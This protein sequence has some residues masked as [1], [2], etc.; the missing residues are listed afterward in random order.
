MYKVVLSGIPTKRPDGTLV[1]EDEV[2]NDLRAHSA[3]FKELALA[4]SA[5]RAGWLLRADARASRDM[6]K[7][8]FALGCPCEPGEFQP[9][10]RERVCQR[11]WNP[12]ARHRERDFRCRERCRLCG[13]KHC[14]EDHTCSTCDVL[15]RACEHI[16]LRCVNC[17]GPHAAD[18]STCEFRRRLRGSQRSAPPMTSPHTASG[19]KSAAHSPTTR[20]RP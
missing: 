8:L 3:A 7:R 4:D 5:E 11:C 19:A 20:H 15:A 17:D 10:D 16:P 13:G 9:R 14:E 2:V 6:K 18:D 1:T 12:Q